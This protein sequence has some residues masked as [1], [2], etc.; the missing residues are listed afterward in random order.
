MKRRVF[1]AILLLALPGFARAGV[2]VPD[3]YRMD[4]Y[5]APVPDRI[6]GG[7][8]VHAGELA[9]LRESGHPIL[10]DVLPAPR[11]PPAMKPGTPWLPAPHLDI[12]GSVW[13][14]DFGRGGLNKVMLAWFHEKLRALT[15][16]DYDRRLV[17]YCQENCWMSWNAAKRAVALGYRRVLW[18]PE[19]VDGWKRSGLPLAAAYPE[20]PP[21][22]APPSP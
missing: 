10:I 9:K 13:L 22:T 4:D 21:Q 1:A 16:G 7:V 2:P 14:P 12:P 20:A 18:F 19:G 8:V 3:D 17:F 15:A 6:P 11:R 5:H